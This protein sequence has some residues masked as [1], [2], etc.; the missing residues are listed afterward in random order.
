[1]RASGPARY[2]SEFRS[3]PLNR[4]R[5]NL[6]VESSGDVF[7]PSQDSTPLENRTMLVSGSARDRT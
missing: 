5:A 7:G 2:I 1:M 4:Q 3:P 6:F